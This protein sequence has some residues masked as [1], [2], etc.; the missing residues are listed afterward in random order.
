MLVSTRVKLEL[1]EDVHMLL[2]FERG[3]RG[4]INGVGE[5]RQFT[6][7]SPHLNTFDPSHKTTFGAFYAVTVTSLY[8][9]TMQEMMPRGNYRWNSEITVKQILK[10][11]ESSNIGYFVEV[12]LKYPQ[13]LHDFHNGLPLAPEKGAIRSSWPS[14]F[15]QS[16]GIKPNK[17]PKLI[18]TLLDK[19]NYVCHY[20]N[21]KLFI[22]HGL[23]VENLH[24]VCEFQQSQWIGVYIE[25]KN[26]MW[27]QATNDFEKKIYKLMTN[28]CF[29]K[30]ME[31][32]RKRSKVEFVSNPQQAEVFAQRATF[33][34]FQTIGQ[35]LVCVSFKIS[36]MVWTKPTPWVLLLSICQNCQCTNAIMSKW[37]LVTLPVI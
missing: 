31:I 20:E 24:R 12:D 29:G 2:F 1:L 10:T 15:A 26:C 25:K 22:K 37:Y 23:T 8:A 6:A 7:N 17:T 36:S 3:I 18:E 27:K 9:G 4:G 32:L 34:S 30:T 11:P 13:H 19:K 14:P 16:F 28:A 35:D 5:L 33:K 21:L